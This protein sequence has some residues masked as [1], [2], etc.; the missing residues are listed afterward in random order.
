MKHGLVGVLVEDDS[1]DLTKSDLLTAGHTYKFLPSTNVRPPGLRN[2]LHFQRSFCAG[3][4][5]AL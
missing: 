4:G 3:L 2:D 1:M 5:S